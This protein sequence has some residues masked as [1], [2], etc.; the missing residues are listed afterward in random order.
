VSADPEEIGKLFDVICSHVAKTS[1]KPT[2]SF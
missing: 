2:D 1:T